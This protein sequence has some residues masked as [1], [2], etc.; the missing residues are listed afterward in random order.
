[1]TAD[2][3]KPNGSCEMH[4]HGHYDNI[5]SLTA[6]RCVIYAATWHESC[7]AL[8]RAVVVAVAFR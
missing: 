3:A 5:Y 7:I 8:T 4:T 6:H 2:R 1:M